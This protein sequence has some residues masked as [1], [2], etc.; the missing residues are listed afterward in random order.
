M[1]D[2]G[3]SCLVRRIES[4]GASIVCCEL[5]KFDSSNQTPFAHEYDDRVAGSYTKEPM[6][7]K[8][9]MIRNAESLRSVIIDGHQASD[10]FLV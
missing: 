4:F 3:V 5:P 8:W 9:P 7:W 1:F 2:E 10:G 6:S